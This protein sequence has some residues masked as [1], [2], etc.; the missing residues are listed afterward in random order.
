MSKAKFNPGDSVIWSSDIG[1]NSKFK[2]VSRREGQTQDGLGWIYL[3]KS[4]QNGA[5]TEVSESKLAAG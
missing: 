4:E 5:S 2:I 3:I 1:G